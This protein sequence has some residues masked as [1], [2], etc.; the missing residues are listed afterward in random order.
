MLQNILQ[1]IKKSTRTTMILI[2]VILMDLLT[3]MEFDLF[4]P[5]FLQL[6]HYFNLTPCWVEALLSVNFI[7][8]CLSLFFVSGRKIWLSAQYLSDCIAVHP[9]QTR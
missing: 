1:A 8:F 2:A 9:F 3:G 7:G 6:Q 5:S 4:V